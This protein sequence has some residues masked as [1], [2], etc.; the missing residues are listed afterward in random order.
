VAIDLAVGLA[1]VAPLSDAATH[2]VAAPAGSTVAAPAAVGTKF[3]DAVDLGSMRGK[4]LAQPVVGIAPTRTGKG[5]WLVARDGGIFSFGD[6]TFFG[7]TG[8]MRLNQPIVGIT[9]SPTGK[10]YWF[11]AADGGIFSFG[12]ARFAGSTGAMRLAQPIVGMAATPTGRGYWLVARDGGIFNFGD[13]TFRGSAVGKA[14]QPIVGM[15]PTATGKGYWL[16]SRDGSVYGFGDATSY[17][18]AAGRSGQGVVGMARAANGAGYW[19]GTTDAAVFPFGSAGD[20]GSGTSSSPVVGI[21]ATP[22]GLGYW[23][24][25]ADGGVISAVSAPAGSGSF[26]FLRIG[27]QST[28]VR[29][30]PCVDQHYVIN[31]A[32]APAGAVDEVKGAFDRLGAATGI[33]F[34]YDG[35]TAES[36]IRFGKRASFQPLL[37]GQRW[38][39]I[40]ISWTTEV[41]E[42]L[43]AGG[44]LGYGGST[45]YWSGGTDEAYVTGEVVFDTNQ[46]VLANGFGPGLTRGNL[47]QHELGH[48]AG[49][50]HV[51]DRGQLMYPSIHS[52]S[53]DGYGAGDRAGLAQLGARQGCLNV[54]KPAA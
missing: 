27:R 49:L 35:T 41:V 42:P 16:V 24:V 13:A 38:A 40:L 51:S 11:V 48:V 37:Y 23:L 10:G 54:A 15:T 3:G 7:S 22:T 36:H 43:L 26:A 53:P 29:Y 46:T 44:T 45:S 31:P 50:D 30:D 12:D 21:A 9:A 33:R 6:A 8:A 2:R 14:A 47:I 4:P 28:P 1:A 32:F 17:G 5:Y 18:S 34:V 20:F 19:L 52:A 39:P 25:S